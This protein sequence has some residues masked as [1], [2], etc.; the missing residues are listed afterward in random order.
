MFPRKY[1]K[2]SK[3]KRFLL[4]LFNVHALE[5]ETLNIVNPNYKN[6]GNNFYRF[7][8]KTFI[9]SSGYL[10]LDRKIQKLDIF[11]R[12]SPKNQL[13]NSTDRWKRIVPKIN[14]EDLIITC[15]I[16]LKESILNFLNNNKMNITIHL[17]SDNSDENFDKSIKNI[18]INDKFNFEFHNS[19]KSGNRGSYLECCDQ[20]EKADDLIFFIED[21]YLFEPICLEELLIT[22]SRI[23]TLIK[24]DIIL[25][26]SDYPFY[27]DSNYKTSLFM[28]KDYR[29]RYVNETLLT[30]VFSKKILQKFRKEIRL[31]GEQ[32]NEPFE[33]PL[34]EIYKKVL[35]LAPVGSLS[36][37]L[38][39]SVPAVNENWTDLWNKNYNKYKKLNV[40]GP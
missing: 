36:Y 38:S 26:P 23:S 11:F 31:V 5:K 1:K 24:D 21:D 18:L 28:G 37:H 12:Y 40:G 35:C 39:R 6:N 16:S 30:I 27:Y 14:K 3:I 22:Y 15:L 32:I 13:W 9:L 34:H 4:K 20:A 17:I 33:K 25:C 8:D 2:Q 29:W 10:E 7:N 19:K